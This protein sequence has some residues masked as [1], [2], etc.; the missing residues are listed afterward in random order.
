MQLGPVAYVCSAVI[1][2]AV[3]SN[4]IPQPAPPARPNGL[5]GIA[6]VQ[7]TNPEPLR[8]YDSRRKARAL[9]E[10]NNFGAAEPLADEIAKAYPIDGQNWLMV[11]RVKR[12]LGKFAEAAAAYR[13]A[14]GLLGP[15]VPGNAEYWQAAMLA[16]DGKNAD[17]LDILTTMVNEDHYLHRPSLFDEEEFKS[18]RDEHRFGDIAGRQDASQWNRNDGWTHDV[19]YLV[20][21]IVRVNPDFHDRPLP[22]AFEQRYKELR[23]RIP[24]LTDEQIYVGMSR[25]IA[26]LNQGHTNLWPFVPAAKMAFK[27]LPLQFYTFPEGIFVVAAGAGNEDLVGAKLVK[28]ESTPAL[29]ALRKIR[30]IHASDS[31]ME[32]LWLGPTFLTL[33]QE[34]KGLG[35]AQNLDRIEVTLL[36]PSGAELTRTLV[37]IPFEKPAM[38]LHGA[39]GRE[40]TL[41]FRNVD[42]AHLLE[43][44]PEA[45]AL[46]VQVNQVADDPD[47][48]LQAF[49]L[50]LRQV[51]K[52]DK[53]RNLVVD[54]RNNNGGNTFF[55]VEFARTLIGF[56]AQENRTL[57]V[58]VGR[59]VYSAA[60]NLVADLERLAN[61]VLVGEPTS[62]TGNAYGDESEVVLPYSGIWAGVTGTK[63][64]LGYPYDLRRAVIPHIP[65]AM[66]ASAYFAG[67]DP[68]LD[69]I[70]ALCTRA[71]EKKPQ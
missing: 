62:M 65:V 64:Q 41:S 30:D 67:R 39:P 37:T 4:S 22:A 48:S 26:A 28:I 17:A 9:L 11:A 7:A 40:P 15:G 24:D 36:R 54:L 16:A 13:K 19:D 43:A 20:A 18:L 33:A 32:I 31:G 29:E 58:I 68:V 60:A 70:K 71:G 50:R 47:E 6:I 12:K 25:M 21:E 3:T 42:K 45:D 46:Y 23:S 44:M 59:G 35:I 61:P 57:Y 34:L 38:K 49:G 63:W 2:A 55:Y 52:D 14:L 69:A 56:S 8:Y 10:Q 1:A 5:D 66:T 53:I 51:L 27:V